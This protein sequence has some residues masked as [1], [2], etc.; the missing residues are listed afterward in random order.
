MSKV[1]GMEKYISKSTGSLN[2]ILHVMEEFERWQQEK[3]A[4]GMKADTVFIPF[5]C[6]KDVHIGDEIRLIY[7]KGY[8][9]KAVVNDI[10]I[11]P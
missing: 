11:M 1:I 8:G 3:G 6:T 7:G 9:G 5:D 10:D 2:T 4:I